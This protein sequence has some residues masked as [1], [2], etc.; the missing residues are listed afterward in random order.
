M[1]AIINMTNRCRICLCMIRTERESM[2]TDRLIGNLPILRQEGRG[3]E[4]NPEYSRSSGKDL[5]EELIV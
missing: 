2:K 4:Q 1:F 5:W 3:E